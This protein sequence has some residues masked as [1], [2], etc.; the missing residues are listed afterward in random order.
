MD[1]ISLSTHCSVISIAVQSTKQILVT[2]YMG[3][4]NADVRKIYH[5]TEL[6]FINQNTQNPYLGKYLL[7]KIAYSTFISFQIHTIHVT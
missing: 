1:R 6:V 3:A 2:R 5:C 4:L 7:S